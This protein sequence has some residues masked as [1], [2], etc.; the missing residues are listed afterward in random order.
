MSEL[1][2][3]FVKTNDKAQLPK[4]N[5]EN[6]INDI[7][8]VKG[9]HDTGYDIFSV[10]DRIV[11]AKGDVVVPV[12]LM[13]GYI[14]PGWWFRIEARSGLSFKYGVI[15]HFGVIDNQYRGD[16]GVK[17]YNLSNE[18]RLLKEGTAVAQ[19]TFYKVHDAIVEWANKVQ[20]TDRGAKGFGSSGNM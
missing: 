1:T 2:V 13:V 8:T 12:G 6:I 17:L 3:R 10:E 14:S 20:E 9:T 19:I 7:G 4:R 16:I 15:P 5:H 11:P 18:D